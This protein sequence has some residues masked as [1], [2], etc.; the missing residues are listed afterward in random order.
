MNTLD[1]DGFKHV[2]IPTARRGITLESLRAMPN[3]RADVARFLGVADKFPEYA[4]GMLSTWLSVAPVYQVPSSVAGDR[5]LIHYRW[6]AQYLEALT[7]W[8]ED[9]EGSAEEPLTILDL[10]TYPF[11]WQVEHERKREQ[12]AWACAFVFHR[13]L[14]YE[15]YAWIR[16]PDVDMYRVPRDGGVIEDPGLV[17]PGVPALIADTIPSFSLSVGVP[18]LARFFLD[19]FHRATG[20]RRDRLEG[21]MEREWLTCVCAEYRRDMDYRC[22]V[23]L[24]GTTLQEKI[25]DFAKDRQG[26]PNNGTVVNPNHHTPY[27]LEFERIAALVRRAHARSQDERKSREEEQVGQVCNYVVY[28]P[29]ADRFL[30]GNR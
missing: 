11:P 30:S 17:F 2:W 29:K 12:T 28:D 15:E 9:E 5:T 21:L 19:S 8:D 25:R 7:T 4:E 26:V 22:R 10:Y 23:V 24:C 27:C 1:T 6:Q 13:V 3:K 16:L 20:G 18:P 14:V